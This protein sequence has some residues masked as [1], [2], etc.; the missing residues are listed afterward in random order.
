M[1]HELKIEKQFA[2]AVLDG[3]K[4]FEVRKNDRGFKAGD[5]VR[6]MVVEQGVATEAV[7]KGHPLNR[8]VYR[9]TY[10]LSGWG[11]NDGYVAFSI[12]PDYVEL[13]E[14]RQ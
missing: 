12:V 14:R 13:A 9:V 4:T 2:D 6:F 3:R 1:L 7:C 10:V 8:A 11:I 5:L